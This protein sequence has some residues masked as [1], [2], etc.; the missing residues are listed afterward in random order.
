MF[1]SACTLQKSNC[2]FKNFDTGCLRM[3]VSHFV[4]VMFCHRKRCMREEN[5]KGGKKIISMSIFKNLQ[6]LPQNKNECYLMK[7]EL[8]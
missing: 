5:G 8:E 1:S 6:Y 2:T 4:F 7:Y 3:G